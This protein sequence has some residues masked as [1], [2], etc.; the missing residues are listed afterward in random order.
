MPPHLQASTL[1]GSPHKDTA[2]RNSLILLG[3]KQFL[4]SCIL[5]EVFETGLR[6]DKFANVGCPLLLGGEGLLQGLK[7]RF[8]F[9]Q[10]ILQP[11]QLDPHGLI[12]GNQDNDL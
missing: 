7:G 2:G 10:I 3:G 6:E 4:E 1:A 5:V 11:G 12:F 8:G 9:S